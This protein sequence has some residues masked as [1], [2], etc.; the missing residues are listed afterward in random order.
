MKTNRFWVWDQLF[1]C[2]DDSFPSWVNAYTAKNT[3]KATQEFRTGISDYKDQPDSSSHSQN[4]LCQGNLRNGK[5]T[6]LTSSIWQDS[7]LRKHLL[8]GGLKARSFCS[9]FSASIQNVN[10]AYISIE[11]LYA[12]YLRTPMVFLYCFIK[13]W[14]MNTCTHQTADWFSCCNHWF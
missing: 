3:C 7:N 14:S 12:A 9:V 5:E 11:N 8:N 4:T 2:D 1:K 6:E 13:A 10:Q